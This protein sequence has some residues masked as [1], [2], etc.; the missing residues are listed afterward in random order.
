MAV[1]RQARRLLEAYFTDPV[2]QYT[3]NVFWDYICRKL[4]LQ[5]G[6][7]VLDVGC[8]WGGLLIHA[9]RRYGVSALGITLAPTPSEIT[10]P[11]ALQRTIAVAK[12]VWKIGEGVES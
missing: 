11:R 8:G 9:A 4:R 10:H 6:E 12:N 3:V 5:S 7:R 1:R 2:V